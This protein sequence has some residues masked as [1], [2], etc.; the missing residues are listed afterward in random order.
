M[1]REDRLY[2]QYGAGNEAI[3]GWLNY[4]SSPTLRIQKAPII[5]RLMRSK[6][7]CI[8]DNEIQYG[9]I[10]K[11]LPLRA[12]SV[13]GL[14]CSHVLEHLSYDDCMTALRNSFLYLKPGGL[15][16]IIIPDL[17]YYVSRYE[18]ARSSNDSHQLIMASYDFCIGTNFGLKETR[19]SISRRLIDAFGANAHRW[20]WDETGLMHALRDNGFVD[21]KRFEQGDSEDEMFLRVERDHQ[22]GNQEGFYGLAIQCQKPL[23]E[24]SDS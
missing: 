22:F 24:P 3:A 8:F 1:T 17:A 7:N 6:L 2:V 14:F 19:N 20:M 5:G 13:D 18:K 10:I 11:G 9:D 23:K 15:F 12:D 16:R 4:D 21:C